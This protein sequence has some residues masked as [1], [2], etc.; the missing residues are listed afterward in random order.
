VVRECAE[1]ARSDPPAAGLNSRVSAR[2][3]TRAYDVS[4][5]PLDRLGKIGAEFLGAKPVPRTG[6]ENTLRTGLTLGELGGFGAAG[7]LARLPFLPAAAAGYG[8]SLGGS[9][10]RW[11]GS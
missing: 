9:R 8:A 10:K 5:D 11:S 3:K 4:G 7:H 6:L 2:S 1:P